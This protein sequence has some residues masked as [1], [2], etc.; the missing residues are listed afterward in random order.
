M[1]ITGMSGTGKSTVLAELSRRGHR[2]VDTDEPG[3]KVATPVGGASE[4]WWDLDRMRAL[5]DAHRS[6]WLFVTGC[7]RNQGQFY[8]RFDAVVLLS[9]PIEVLLA[10]VSV[11]D[12]PF[13][14]TPQDRAEIADDLATFEPV[15]RAGVDHEITTTAPL[16]DVVRALEGFAASVR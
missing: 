4:P 13:G 16:D 7:V 15:L 6:G 2:V 5:L 1:L 14:S 11:R 10:R 12:N 8:D 9:A 3:W